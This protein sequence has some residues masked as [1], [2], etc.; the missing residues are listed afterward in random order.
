ML[1]SLL[2]LAHGAAVT[3]RQSS[4]ESADAAGCCI[5]AHKLLHCHLAKHALHR[6]ANTAARCLFAKASHCH[7]RD[8]WEHFLKDISANA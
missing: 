3:A 8:H 1:V 2:L 5:S 4:Q 6:A 7:H